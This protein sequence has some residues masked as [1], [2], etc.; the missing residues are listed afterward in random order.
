MKQKLGAK[1]VRVHPQL[2]KLMEAPDKANE[3][4]LGQ[5]DK[6]LR[7]TEKERLYLDLTGL[8]CYHKA[9]VP[10]WYDKLSEKD[11]CNVQARFWQAVAG[12]CKDS[13]A[14]FCYDLMNESVVAGRKRKEGDWLPA[15][16]AGKHFVQFINLEQQDRPR[17]DIARQWARHLTAAIRE[18]DKRHLITVGLVDR[19]LDRPGLTSGFVPAKI[20]DDLDFISVHLYPKVGKVKDAL[21]TLD[22]FSIGKPVV[23]EETFPLA[24]SPKELEE[25]IDGSKKFATG[26]IG[27]YWGKSPE[28]LRRSNTISGALTLGWLGL[29]EKKAKALEK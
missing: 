11:R 26:W 19:S 18:K 1:I 23:I 25:F 6:L 12:R 21:E 7:L 22:G 28:E 17:P 9:D 8:G 13:P 16:F 14:V 2:G 10:A 27:F 15:P 4:A 20:A 24:C 29:F 3:K 5:L